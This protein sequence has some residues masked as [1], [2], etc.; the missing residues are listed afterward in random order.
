MEIKEDHFDWKFEVDQQVWVVSARSFGVV[1]ER[2]IAGD[3]HAYYSVK[4]QGRCGLPIFPTTVGDEDLLSVEE[5]AEVERKRRIKE[6]EKEYEEAQ[7]ERQ[8]SME[9][10]EDVVEQWAQQY[11][12][13]HSSEYGPSSSIRNDAEYLAA[14]IRTDELQIEI[15]AIRKACKRYRRNR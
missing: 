8:I 11:I 14:L 15:D 3:R 7:R 12:H 6:D 9:E 2:H 10:Q 5:H 13:G 4:G 1:A